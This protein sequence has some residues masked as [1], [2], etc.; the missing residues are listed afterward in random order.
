MTQI[1]FYWSHRWFLVFRRLNSNTECFVNTR[2][3]CLGL[4]GPEAGLMQDVIKHTKI[5]VVC[6]H[7]NL[8]NN[9]LRRV[10]CGALETLRNLRSLWVFFSKLK[11]V[12]DV[13]KVRASSSLHTRVS[14]HQPGDDVP[15]PS[16]T[17]C[18]QKCQHA[19]RWMCDLTCG[20]WITFPPGP[21]TTETQNRDQV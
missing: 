11:S 1:W 18:S 20:C 6:V 7:R 12:F 14:S 9:Q 2:S 15:E 5:I 19:Q 17:T 13:R 8:H 21:V 10:P 4:S 3:F 16:F